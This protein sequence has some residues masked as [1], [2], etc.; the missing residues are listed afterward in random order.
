MVIQGGALSGRTVNNAAQTVTVR[1]RFDEN[2][3]PPVYSEPQAT[4]I[5]EKK[6]DYLGDGGKDSDSLTNAHT[7]DDNAKND[8]YRLYLDA[9]IRPSMIRRTAAS[10]TP[11]C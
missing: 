8:L 11:S 6:I 2:A 5:A 7:T 1:N 10:R 4:I 9:T 3:P